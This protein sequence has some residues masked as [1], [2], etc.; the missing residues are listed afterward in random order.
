MKVFLL[1]KISSKEILSYVNSNNLNSN[2]L[3]SIGENYYIIQTKDKFN[4][5]ISAPENQNKRF[6]YIIENLIKDVPNYDKNIDII[7]KKYFGESVSD[8]FLQVWEIVLNFNLVTKNVS[9]NNEI[10]NLVFD[11]LKKYTNVSVSKSKKYTHLFLLNTITLTTR[12]NDINKKITK[13][14]ENLN[15]LEKSGTL[16]IKIKD[17][18]T[19]SSMHLIYMLSYL[20][21]DVYIYRPEFSYTSHGEKYIVCTNFSGKQLKYNTDKD[22]ILL[23]NV[24]IPPEYIFTLNIINRILMQEEYIMLSIMR[25]YIESQNYY[26]EEYHKY[27]AKQESNSDKWISNNLMLSSKDYNEL[28]KIKEDELEKSIEEYTNLIEERTKMYL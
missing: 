8:E 21:E 2:P 3:M 4:K 7:T 22:Y 25:T 13:F 14:I 9:T 28:I 20:F 26:G 16:V 1:P 11:K 23:N 15:D 19:M 10:A 5:L 24:E 27:L 6:Y 17:T 12:E 18:V